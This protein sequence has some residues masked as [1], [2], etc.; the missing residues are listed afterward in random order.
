MR[1]KGF[2]LIEL[3]V[4]IAIIAILAAILFPVFAKARE[5]ART[6]S[7]QSNLKQLSIGLLQYVQDY[8]ET[9]PKR[10]FA[11]EAQSWRMVIQ[12][13]LKSDQVFRCP[14]NTTNNNLSLDGVIRCS[15]GANGQDNQNTP[16]NRNAVVALAAIDAPAQLIMLA[17]TTRTWSEAP[18][19][20]NTGTSFYAGHSGMGNF[21]FADGHVKSLKWSSTGTPANLWQ[22]GAQGSAASFQTNLNG[23][24]AVY[25]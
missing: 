20:T 18:I 16:M 3:L 22:L 12:P 7:C 11:V 21:A 4:V 9:L 13:Y 10:Y 25:P 23:V 19:M 1:R 8:D 24:D 2:T 6:S 14:S 5:K 15:Y 17:E